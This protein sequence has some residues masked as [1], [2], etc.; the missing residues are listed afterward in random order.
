MLPIIGIFLGPIFMV[1]KNEPQNMLANFLGLLFCLCLFIL[2]IDFVYF[3]FSQI[4]KLKRKSLIFNDKNIVAKR[5]NK[6]EVIIY[7]IVSYF[8]ITYSYSIIYLFVG[9][10]SKQ[11]FNVDVV[12]FIDSFFLSFTTMSVGPS[13]LQPNTVLTKT[14]VMSEIFVG[15]LFMI[16]GLSINRHVATVML[17][18]L[19]R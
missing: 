1:S 10:Y 17:N 19:D 12:T 7:I 16:L 14:L 6:K 11:S 8:F 3:T 4:Y 9:N 2:I 15:I 18:Q 13:G 5:L